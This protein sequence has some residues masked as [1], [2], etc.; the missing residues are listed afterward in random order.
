MAY[1]PSKE[2]K[3]IALKVVLQS[4][5]VRNWIGAMARFHGVNLTTDEGRKWAKTKSIELAK[6]L[7]S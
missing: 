6:L 2:D 7:I 3:K 4:R 5:Y 1:I